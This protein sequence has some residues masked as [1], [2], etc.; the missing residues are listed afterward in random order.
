MGSHSLYDEDIKHNI[1][2]TT[3][4]V[5]E[6]WSRVG[7]NGDWVWN[8]NQTVPVLTSGGIVTYNQFTGATWQNTPLTNNNFVNYYIL[9]YNS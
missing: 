8:E 9:S 4:G 2:A 7:V 3:K 1:P 5:Y 6:V